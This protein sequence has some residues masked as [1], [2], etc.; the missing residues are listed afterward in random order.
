[1]YA[2]VCQQIPSSPFSEKYEGKC[3]SPTE[4]SHLLNSLPCS[5]F[6]QRNYNYSRILPICPLIAEVN[7]FYSDSVSKI[8][9]YL[10]ICF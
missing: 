7:K 2:Q 3:L 5:L 9:M 1:M 6:L 10:K 4:L 8:C